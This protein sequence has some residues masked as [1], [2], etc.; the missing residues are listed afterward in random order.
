MKGLQ[1]V[2]NANT[3]YLVIKHGCLCQESRTMRDGYDPIEL[4]DRDNPGVTYFK[5]IKPWGGVE[6]MVTDIQFRNEV[7]GGIPY[8]SWRISLQADEGSPMV[9]ELPLNSN[10][11]DRF[12][13][14]AEAL[15]FTKPVEFRAWQ[16]KESKKTAFMILQDDKNVSQLYTKENPGDM[17]P[18]RQRFDKT[19]DFEAQKEFLYQRM[20]EV[21][22]PRVHEANG[23]KPEA[24]VDPAA[25]PF[26]K[27]ETRAEPPAEQWQNRQLGDDPFARPKPPETATARPQGSAT[28][29]A[30]PITAATVALLKAEAEKRPDLNFNELAQRTFQK[31]SV[32]DLTEGAGIAMLKLVE[33]L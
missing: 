11:G 21:V 32:M 20:M 16:E 12:M 7:F 5:Y 2:R 26:A 22:I 17:P 18:A 14:T 10:V 29:T 23:T 25:D 31:A 13:K 27:T 28:G 3:I 15:D 4:A 9:L 1:P 33:H 8:I 30:G 24:S 6:A 19:W